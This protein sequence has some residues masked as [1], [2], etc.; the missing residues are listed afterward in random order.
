MNFIELRD[1]IDKI[2]KEIR[3]KQEQFEL[4]DKVKFLNNVEI[5]GE[6]YK[7]SYTEFYG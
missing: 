3:E 6:I 2:A 1:T 5:K 7:F 4:E